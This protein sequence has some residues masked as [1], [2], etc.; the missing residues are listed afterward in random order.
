MENHQISREKNRTRLCVDELIEPA[1]K[2]TL[3]MPLSPDFPVNDLERLR[4]PGRRRGGLLVAAV[5]GQ[6]DQRVRLLRRQG[7]HDLDQRYPVGR[8]V[9]GVGGGGWCQ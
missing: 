4:P 8:E 3:L 1:Q 9:F 7:A 5:P 2:L 6:G